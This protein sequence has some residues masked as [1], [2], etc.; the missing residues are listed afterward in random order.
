MLLP[1]PSS[2]IVEVAIGRGSVPLKQL[3]GS[4]F[5][6]A[7]L[8]REN[9]SDPNSGFRS[10]AHANEQLLAHRIALRGPLKGSESHQG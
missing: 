3:L 6:F 4:E 1:L 10:M 2:R 7:K 8:Y 9:Y 5:F